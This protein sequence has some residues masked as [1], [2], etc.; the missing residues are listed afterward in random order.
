[1]DYRLLLARDFVPVARL[2]NGAAISEF[3]RLGKPGGGSMD[4]DKLTRAAEP[5][6]LSEYLAG[7]PMGQMHGHGNMGR[8]E[9]V[10]TDDHK[11]HHISI[12]TIYEIEVDGKPLMVPLGLDNSGQ[13]HCHALPN[14]QFKSA[15][16]LVKL[17]IDVFPKDFTGGGSPGGHSG[18]H[19]QQDSQSGNQKEGSGGHPHM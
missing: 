15:I 5:T 3:N 10:R 8:V 7:M 6:A 11:G 18:G 2:P 1:V 4:K 9:T 17:L 12:K 13:L 19:G 14:Y 16:D